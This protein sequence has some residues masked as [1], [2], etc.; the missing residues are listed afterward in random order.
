MK[1][2]II[3]F[4][5]TMLMSM[6]GAMALA[7]TNVSNGSCFTAKTIEGVDV[8]Y[9]ITDI[10]QRTVQVGTSP[11]NQ[12]W[13]SDNYASRVAVNTSSYGSVTIPE[14]VV[15]GGI[16]YSVTFIANG[17][18]CGCSQLTDIIIPESVTHIGHA[19][20]DHCTSLTSIYLP[21]SVTS[22]DDGYAFVDCTSLTNVRLSE[23]L[24]VIPNDT[25]TRCSSLTTL[26]IPEGVTNLGKAVHYNKG[27]AFWKCSALTSVDIPSSV[28]YYVGNSFSECTNLK[29]VIV[30]RAEPVSI[31]NNTFEN[32]KN[33][34]LYVPKGSKIAYENAAVWKEFKEI[35]ES[36]ESVIDFAD[37]NQHEYVDLGLPS[38]TLWATFNI[39]ADSPEDYGDYFAWGETEG[40]KS[41]KATFD[42]STYNWCNGSEKKLIKYCYDSS[43]GYNGFTDDKTE[44]DPEDDAAYVN[45]GPAWRMPSDKQF[46]E[47]INSSNT[48]TEWTTQ[49]GVNGCLIT[50]NTNG[51]TLFLPVTG[52]RF[53]GSISRADYGYYWSRTLSTRK[54]DCAICLFLYD[55]SF[56]TFARYRGNCVRP[57]RHSKS[58]EDTD[59]SQLDNA[60]YI[61]PT[62]ARCGSQ[63]T[64]SVKMKNNVPIQT[65]QFDLYLPDGITIVPNE[66]DELVTASK[67]R[68]NKFNYFESSMQ[69]DGAL[70]LLAQAT[71]TNV[72][73]GDGEICRIV[74]NIP[75]SMERGDY[76]LIIKGALMVEKN[77]TSHSPDPNQVQTKL[78]VLKYVLGDASND[79]E[80]NAI[81]FN[82]IGNHILG[83]T[84]EGF[85]VKAADISGDGDVN[86]IDFNI[87][88]NMI[89]NG[90]PASA[91]ERMADATQDPD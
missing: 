83:Q 60:I 7:Q 59:I 31:D 75:E 36:S 8:S 32:R 33:A 74:A 16:E 81:D 58:I 37:D 12:Y 23:N 53:D 51:N 3:T 39:G 2:Q 67:E 30:R 26:T 10:S 80:V 77:N 72:P 90:F 55:F 41:G 43:Y 21:N 62:E 34:T 54:P 63:T 38:G 11:S 57:V 89:L 79:G 17:A 25:F 27:D 76:P 42:W 68:I 6:V 15:Y 49:N 88:G 45:W 35:I 28:T 91:R 4:L 1:R 86:A 5:L 52:Y 18:F 14:K 82:M 20:F 48:T 44:L 40:F 9:M 85:N 19:A 47:L 13:G 84:Q 46:Q 70:R 66:D 73:A 29:T 56:D 69:T 24:K 50:S 22:I 78:T 87:V 64:L 61:E 71:S 65:I